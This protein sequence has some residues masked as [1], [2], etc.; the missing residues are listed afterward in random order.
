[1]E[2]EN[3]RLT[4]L[5]KMVRYEFNLHYRSQFEAD[6]RK[7]TTDVYGK[8]PVERLTAAVDSLFT[9]K[10]RGFIVL[11]DFGVGKTSMLSLVMKEYLKALVPI[12]IK[13]ISDKPE[14]FRILNDTNFAAI[15]NPINRASII[16]VSQ[17]ELINLLRD[18]PAYLNKRIV[19]IDDLGRGYEDRSGWNLALQTEYL[20]NRYI[21][22]LPTFITTSKET[23]QLREWDGWELIVD[24]IGHPDWLDS[25]R[26]GGKSKR[27]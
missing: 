9:D 22:R 24:R 4:A 8:L 27:K 15:V 19:L 6:L 16:C 11:G 26:I 23:S 20:E 12:I 13:E 25:F 7:A 3:S 5:E 17:E 18:Y 21:K 10:P 1:M 14:I 2:K